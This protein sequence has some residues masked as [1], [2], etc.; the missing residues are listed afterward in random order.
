M[1]DGLFDFKFEPSKSLLKKIHIIPTNERLTEASGLGTILEIFDQSGFKCEFMRCL[2]ERKSPRSLGSY[3]LALNLIAGF[4]YGFDSLDDFDDFDQEEGIQ[5]LFG[6]G[7]A[8]A[9]TL[10][11]F[12]RDFE[13]EHLEKLN[14]FLSSMSW[15]MMVSLQRNL[16]DQFKPKKI[17]LDIDSTSHPQSGNKIEGCAWSYKNE[18][19]LDSQEIFNQLGFCHSFKLR[20]GN[21]KSG[22]GGADQLSQSLLDGRRQVQKKLTGDVLVRGDSAYCQQE[23]IKACLDRGSLFTLTAHDGT[24]NWKDLFE[25]QGCDWKPWVY[26]KEEIEKAQIRKA[27]LPTVEVARI[28]WTPKWS[29]VAGA[30]L[31]FPIVIKRTLDKERFE[32]LRRKGEQARLFH[33]DGYMKEDPYDYYAVLTNFP[34]DL[35]TD[36]SLATEAQAKMTRYSLQEV[37]EHHQKRGNMENFIREEKNA[38]DLKHFPCLKLSANHAYGLLAMVSHNLLRWV[39]MMMKPE[40]PQFAKKLRKR[41]VF[42]PGK[43]VKHAR[44]LY[45]KIVVWGFK[46]VS[47]LREAWG[48]QPA[49]IPHQYSSA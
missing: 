14:Q 26:T 17:C 28:H 10:G 27:E 44:A 18:W 35:A 9:R 43:I 40:K 30:K 48:F 41:F 20:P 23:V 21:T 47:K 8:K 49:K 19:C 2:P 39:A 7:T 12:L 24:T 34:L 6:E 1:S 42:T 31:V 36:K 5:A 4:I 11:D 25:S 46:E 33:D 15:G 38:F 22:V 13:P 3:R 45:L 37:L 29:V 16:P 32:E